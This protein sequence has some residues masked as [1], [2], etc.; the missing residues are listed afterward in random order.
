MNKKIRITLIVVGFSALAVGGAYLPFAFSWLE[1]SITT[2]WAHS[3]R[4]EPTLTGHWQGKLLYQGLAARNITLEIQHEPRKGR[5]GG[6]T[7][8]ARKGVFDGS[9]T[10]TDAQGLNTYTISGRANRDGSKVVIN[11]YHTN[12]KPSK[13]LQPVLQELQGV[14]TGKGLTLSGQYSSDIFD[15]TS[16]ISNSDTP[17]LPVTVSLQKD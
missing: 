11:F 14:W 15:G 3:F 17:I 4:G 16:T 1:D 2:P 9:A 12:R 7:T 13:Q 6:T 5:H 10:I 8:Y